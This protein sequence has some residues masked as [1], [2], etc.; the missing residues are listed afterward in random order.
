MQQAMEQQ[1]IYYES[2]ENAKS[3][4]KSL[5]CVIDGMAVEGKVV[6]TGAASSAPSIAVAA[7]E[8]NFVYSEAAE[9]AKSL[10]KSLGCVIDGEA[11]EAATA[12]VPAPPGMAVA[13]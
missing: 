2:A 6:P 10:G 3:L 7:M 5:G 4:G 11:V 13:A 1:F 8:Q 12:T 9:N